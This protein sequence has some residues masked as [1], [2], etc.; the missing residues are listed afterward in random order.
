MRLVSTKLTPS[1]RE[2]L[3]LLATYER[4]SWRD[5]LAFFPGSRASLARALAELERKGLVKKLELPRRRILYE[6]TEQGKRVLEETEK[7]KVE[8][9]RS[10]REVFRTYVLHDLVEGVGKLAEEGKAAE[11]EQALIRTLGELLL[12]AFAIAYRWSRGEEAAFER[13]LRDI[14]RSFQPVIW[15]AWWTLYDLAKER[16]EVFEGIIDKIIRKTE[17]RL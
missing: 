2:V 11:A 7:G 12:S 17:E 16:P 9:I 6:V 8:T 1:E 13:R 15:T 3:A 14:Q 5:L 10:I 4:G